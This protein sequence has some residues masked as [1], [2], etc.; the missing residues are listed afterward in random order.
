[1]QLATKNNK[2][3]TL[4]G[5][6]EHPATKGLVCAKALFLPKIVYSPDRLTKPQIRKNGKLEDATWEEAMDLVAKRFAGDIKNHGSDSVAYYGSGQ[7]LSEESYLAN[8]LFK[9]GDWYK[10]R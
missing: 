10:Q 7:C 6:P 8:R 9:G 2:L 5:D 3:V 1:M 4:R